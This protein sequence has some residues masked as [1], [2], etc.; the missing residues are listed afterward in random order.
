[1]SFALLCSL[2]L[3]GCEKPA[4]MASDAPASPATETNAM[5]EVSAVIAPA[6]AASICKAGIAKLFQQPVSSMKAVPVAGGIIR[7]SYR[8]SSDNTLWSNDCRLEGDRIVWR[9]VDVSPGSGPGRWRDDPA[10]GRVTYSVEGDE[11]I[12]EETF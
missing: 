8:R 6:K 5:P 3:L 7:V 11:I 4:Q 1:M 10:D 12:V 9:A 2:S